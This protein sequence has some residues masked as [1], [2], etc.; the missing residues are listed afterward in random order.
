[1]KTRA[2][3]EIR[4]VILSKGYAFFEN[5]DYN[6]NIIAVR[7]DDV[8]DNKFSDTLYVIYKVSGKW[9][10]KTFPW[11]TLA[12]LYGK[13]GEKQPYTASETGTEEGGVA[14]ILEGQYR[15]AFKYVPNGW[16]YP[17]Q[18]Y[19]QQVKGLNYLRDND[20]NG[21]I[22][23]E[24]AIGRDNKNYMTHLHSMSPKGTG[25]AS[26]L[27][28]YPGYSPWSAGCNGC[29]NVEFEQ[30]LGIVEKAV[31]LWGNVFTY[32]LLH[33]KDFE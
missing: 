29:P 12:G 19:L 11:T 10:I 1:M 22:S 21:I 25:G 17:F 30:F 20:K 27:V 2:I 33:A 23:R 8:F 26:M 5:G 28:S 24:T 3:E 7:E 13:G 9:I 16:K 15:G 31:P 4:N 32:T 6:L 14:I 18:R